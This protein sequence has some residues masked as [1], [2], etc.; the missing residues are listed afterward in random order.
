M[1]KTTYREHKRVVDNHM[2]IQTKDN[3]QLERLTPN[4]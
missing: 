1:P 3:G 2:N 4:R